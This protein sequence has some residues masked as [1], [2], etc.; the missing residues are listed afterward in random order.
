MPDTD[1]PPAWRFRLIL[2][3]A[4]AVFVLLV[5]WLRSRVEI[6]GV[7]RR[8]TAMVGTLR[9]ILSAQDAHQ[10]RTGRYASSLDSLGGWSAPAGLTVSFGAPAPG[11]WRVTVHDPSLEVAPTR[12]GLFVGQPEASPHRAVIEP[13]VPACW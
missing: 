3:T 8:R 13:G 1:S 6:T 4:L 7:E 2:L 5:L 12:C 9:G 10:A 11:T